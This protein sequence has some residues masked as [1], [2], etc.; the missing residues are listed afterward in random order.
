MKLSRTGRIGRGYALIAHASPGWK[1]PI[2]RRCWS[3]PVW[4][5][6]LP[7]CTRAVIVSTEWNQGL[8][9]VEYKPPRSNHICMSWMLEYSTE[10]M[11]SF[12]IMLHV[13]LAWLKLR[14][15]AK[16]RPSSGVDF[17]QNK[18]LITSLLADGC[19]LGRQRSLT[20][21]LESR[22]NSSSPV[23]NRLHPHSRSF[24][25]CFCVRGRLSKLINALCGYKF[26][27]Y[28]VWK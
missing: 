23:L 6:A 28:S 13:G 10:H 18:I 25:P 26:L 21:T 5:A 1:P 8:K 19:T 12:R 22:T 14:A 24:K 27:W 7:F 9:G 16:N 2:S 3:D 4:A 15:S 20:L 11:R 17:Y